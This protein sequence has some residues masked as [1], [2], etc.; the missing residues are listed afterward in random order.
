MKRTFAR[1]LVIGL[2]L[3]VGAA[4]A[5]HAQGRG[6]GGGGPGGG[7]PPGGGP[8]GGGM[9]GGGM[10][11]GRDGGGVSGPGFPSG[12]SRPGVIEP[13]GNMPS[14][15]QRN[16]STEGGHPGLQV[17]PPGRWW[18]D[19]GFARNLKLRPDQQTRM[20]S[21]FEQNRGAL[22][23]RFQGVQQAQA[24]LETLSRSPS[25]DEAALFA[26]I[27]R[28]AQARAELE[29]ANTHYLLQLRKEMDADQIQRLEKSLQ[30]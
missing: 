8:G 2:C 7:G 14:Q 10:G 23:N 25:P 27:D 26:Q 15:P 17:G 30:R 16:P 4:S 24:Q 22:L 13:R 19:R 11:G 18:D 9:G 1:N 5:S 6:P 29:K 21:I 28:V 3:A 12:G 20:D